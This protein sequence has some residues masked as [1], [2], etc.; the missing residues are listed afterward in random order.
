MPYY[1][2]FGFSLQQVQGWTIDFWLHSYTLKLHVPDIGCFEAAD[3]KYDRF[4]ICVGICKQTPTTLYMDLPGQKLH[5]RER[6]DRNSL[7][8]LNVHY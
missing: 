4:P 2:E 7:F 6:T 1:P 3:N 5:T 8:L